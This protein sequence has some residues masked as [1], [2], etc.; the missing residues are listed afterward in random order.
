MEA[1]FSPEFQSLID[2]AQN[3]D[4]LRKAAA[5]MFQLYTELVNAGFKEDQ[6][7]YII[8]STLNGGNNND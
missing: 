1:K 5:M 4:E 7:L 3:R 2:A 6:A 8:T